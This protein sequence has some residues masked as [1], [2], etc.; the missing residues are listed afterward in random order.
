M[1]SAWSGHPGL[2]RDADVPKCFPKAALAEPF[3]YTLAL[4]ERLSL[5]LL[6]GELKID[7]KLIES[8]A[9]LPANHLSRYPCSARQHRPT[10]IR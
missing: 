5:F 7:N 10:P 4:W 1:K 2:Q 8:A 9:G 6:H 3:G